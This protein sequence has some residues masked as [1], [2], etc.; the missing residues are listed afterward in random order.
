MLWCL[1]IFYLNGPLSQWSK[2]QD[3]HF[4]LYTTR[5]GI[6]YKQRDKKKSSKATKPIPIVPLDLHLNYGPLS[7]IWIMVYYSRSQLVGVMS[8]YISWFYVIKNIPKKMHHL[9][10][11]VL[12]RGYISSTKSMPE[13]V[14]LAAI[15]KL[16]IHS[17]LGISSQLK[18][19]RIYLKLIITFYYKGSKLEWYT[20]TV[21]PLLQTFFTIFINSS[22]KVIVLPFSK[23][24]SE[25]LPGVMGH[26]LNQTLKKIS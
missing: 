5:T 8:K 10:L 7:S 2:A 11:L 1:P 21:R 12:I 9:V 25:S 17:P 13:P 3:G 6:L 23:S 20:A 19:T 16:L 18:T 24:E 26:L 22:V 14:E 15:S 4:K